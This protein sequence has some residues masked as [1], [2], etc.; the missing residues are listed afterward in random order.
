MKALPSARVNLARS[1]TIDFEGAEK[2]SF[3]FEIRSSAAQ[4]GRPTMVPKGFD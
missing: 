4:P 2:I 3:E 1:V